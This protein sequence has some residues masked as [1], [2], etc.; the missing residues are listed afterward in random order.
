M[1]H[2]LD[3]RRFIATVL[4]VL[5]TMMATPVVLLRMVTGLS[6]AFQLVLFIGGNVDYGYA[7]GQLRSR[8][9]ECAH[10]GLGSV[11]GGHIRLPL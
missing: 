6:L 10:T 2:P 11:V 8:L 7:S 9:E 3:A 4:C 1:L 5:K